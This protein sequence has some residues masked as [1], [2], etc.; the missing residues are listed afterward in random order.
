VNVKLE[1]ALLK[2]FLRLYVGVDNLF[3]K[4][5]EESY[6]FPRPGRFIYGGG[7]LIF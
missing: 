3:D 2:D 5:Y 1:Q 7:R 6:A 4:D